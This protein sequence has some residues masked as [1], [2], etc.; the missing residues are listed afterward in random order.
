MTQHRQIWGP[1]PL[2]GLSRAAACLSREISAPG[3]PRASCWCRLLP[4]QLNQPFLQVLLGSIQVIEVR[5]HLLIILLPVCH[6]LAE[7]VVILLDFCP[8]FFKFLLG[9]GGEVGSLPISH[10]V[11][12]P[13]CLWANS[14]P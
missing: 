7:S 1:F 3:R 10:C 9:P 6:L 12:L 4:E 8:G 11:Q 5:E 2:R 13:P 14:D